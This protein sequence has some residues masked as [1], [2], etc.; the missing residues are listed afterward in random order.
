MERSKR[1]REEEIKKWGEK[2]NSGEEVEICFLILDDFSLSLTI[3][4]FARRCVDLVCQLDILRK[5]FPV[6]E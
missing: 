3:E 6:R 1:R 5:N 2:N 4:Y